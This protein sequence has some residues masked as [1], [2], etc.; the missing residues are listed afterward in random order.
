MTAQGGTAEQWHDPTL[1][2]GRSQRGGEL[3]HRWGSASADRL[4]D[5]VVQIRKRVHQLCPEHADLVLEGLGDRHVDALAARL[6]P[7]R[8]ATDQVHHPGQRH[9]L[10]AAADRI[11]DHQRS[12][13]QLLADRRRAGEDICSGALTL[14]HERERRE[15]TPLHLTPD[16]LRLRLDP[17]GRVHHHDGTVEHAHAALDLDGEVHVPRGIDEVDL[18]PGPPDSGRGRR[19]RDPALPLLGHPVHHG[20]PLV[21]PPDPWLAT[22][23]VQDALGQ[24]GLTG[25]DVRAD[26][27]VPQ[28]ADGGRALA[29]LARWVVRDVH[30]C[31]GIL[32]PGVHR[33]PHPTRSLP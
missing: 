17:A 23:Q 2:S 18:T 13:A 24:R 30:G 10:I 1:M 20:G 21:H 5:A 12:R 15:A 33:I 6:D 19:D 4:E 27:D 31:G 11:G 22:A 8:G 9:L 3:L 14:V 28:R 29:G 7:L 26:A 25:V 32:A 16:R